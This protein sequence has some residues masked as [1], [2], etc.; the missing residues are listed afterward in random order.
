MKGLPANSTC[1][2]LSPTQLWDNKNVEFLS[3]P[4]IPETVLGDRSNPTLRGLLY[5]P[6]ILG[7]FVLL[8]NASQM[9]IDVQILLCR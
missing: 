6:I 3:D 4:D 8:V 5:A 2:L 7:I 1:M 9:V